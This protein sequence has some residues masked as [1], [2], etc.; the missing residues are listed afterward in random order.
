MTYAQWPEG[1]RSKVAVSWNLHRLMPSDMDFLIFLSS[2]AGIYGSSSQCNY[3]AGHTFQDALA[4]ARTSAGCFNGTSV[5]LDLG[6]M[7]DIGVISEREEYQ[8]V[9][10]NSRD[11]KPVY[12]ADLLV[13]LDHYCD[14]ETPRPQSA[15]DSQLLVG[16]VTPKTIAPATSKQ[17]TGS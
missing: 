8:V 9:R 10:E 3:S 5:S 14:P 15:Q 7:H 4:Q 13:L 6:W 16:T 17:Y 12:A 1:T 11:M 2:L